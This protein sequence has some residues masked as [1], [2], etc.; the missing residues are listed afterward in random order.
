MIASRRAACDVHAGDWAVVLPVVIAFLARCRATADPN[1][2][3]QARRDDR[4][5]T[6][7]APPE[8]R[9][10]QSLLNT[11]DPIKYWN[12]RHG[13]YEANGL[14]RICWARTAGIP[15]VPVWFDNTTARPP[16]DAVLLQRGEPSH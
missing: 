16:S 3:S 6:S 4:H 13:H 5:I 2:I 8:F 1:A 9:L 14:H 7:L 11:R 12:N 10:A 15:A